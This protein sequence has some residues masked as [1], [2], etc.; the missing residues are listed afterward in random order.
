MFIDP[1]EVAAFRLGDLWEHAGHPWCHPASPVDPHPFPG[2]IDCHCGRCCWCWAFY[3]FPGS[4][5]PGRVEEHLRVKP[6]RDARRIKRLLR[7]DD[8]SVLRR[9]SD[10]GNG[11]GSA[12]GVPQDPSAGKAYPGLC[13]FLGALVYQDGSAREPGSITITVDAGRFRLSLND[14]DQSCSATVTADNIG[15]GIKCLEKK[16]QEDTLD[17]RAWKK[18]LT[19]RR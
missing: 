13:E 10:G 18:P 15:E 17:W 19:R 5:P 4:V 12:G 6:Q 1:L 9:F 2:W 7:G 11:P 3:P 8:V 14:K 16:L